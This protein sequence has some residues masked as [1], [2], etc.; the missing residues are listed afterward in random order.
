MLRFSTDS[1]ANT[2]IVTSNFECT[3]INVSMQRFGPKGATS[4]IDFCIWAIYKTICLPA[5][6]I[7]KCVP[8]EGH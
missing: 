1:Q 4:G 6:F 5:E 3:K 7:V 2:R 8:E